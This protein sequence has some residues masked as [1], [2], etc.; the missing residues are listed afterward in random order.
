MR[1]E[2]THDKPL[3][4]MESSKG[5]L[6][7]YLNLLH[8]IKCKSSGD[9]I[10]GKKYSGAIRSPTGPVHI[11]KGPDKTWIKPSHGWVK[12]S[13]DGSFSATNGM[14]GAGMVLRDADGFPISTACRLWTTAKRH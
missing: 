7:N 2:A 13:V 5:F 8:D 4:S 10:K 3:P 12:L 11:K 9:I 1:N 14:A 6:C